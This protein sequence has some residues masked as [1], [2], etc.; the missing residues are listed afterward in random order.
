MNRKVTLKEHYIIIEFISNNL[1]TSSTHNWMSQP[2]KSTTRL[3]RCSRSWTSTTSRTC[4]QLNTR[5]QVNTTDATECN[6][7]SVIFVVQ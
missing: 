4:N 7:G 1:F 5:P 3:E 6:C 2:S